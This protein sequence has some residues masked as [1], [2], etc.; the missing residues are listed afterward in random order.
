[1]NG[2]HSPRYRVL[3]REVASLTRPRSLD[4]AA[5]AAGLRVWNGPRRTDLVVVHASGRFDAPAPAVA[6]YHADL[7]R[8]YDPDLLTATEAEQPGIAVAIQAALGDGYAVDQVAEYLCIR[9]VAT[10]AAVG[11][12]E[13]VRLTRTEGLHQDW[14]NLFIGAFPL[15]LTSTGCDLTVTV[16][17]CPSAV[18]AGDRYDGRRVLV[19]TSRT[20]FRKWGKWMDAQPATTL[21]LACMDSNLDH[22]R[23]AW[24]VRLHRWLHA[25]SIWTRRRPKTG[26]HAGRRLIDAIYIRHGRTS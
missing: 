24:R 9:K 26:S 8:H 17:H 11:T 15:R 23:L 2:A 14:R 13:R 20:G 22:H 12:P 18:Q 21:L 16:G 5:V 25:G 6:K 1:M 3:W 4:H 7:I 19:A 10:V